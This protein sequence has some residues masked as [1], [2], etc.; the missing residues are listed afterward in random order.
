MPIHTANEDAQAKSLENLHND[1]L[2]PILINNGFILGSILKRNDIDN[3][4]GVTSLA[5]GQ[6][7]M[8]KSFKEQFAKNPELLDFV[9]GISGGLLA[10]TTLH[11]LDVLKIRLAGTSIHFLF[12]FLC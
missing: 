4:N 10:T 11:P 2:K 6:Q 8:L 1:E 5:S 9:A 7:A 12:V 3:S